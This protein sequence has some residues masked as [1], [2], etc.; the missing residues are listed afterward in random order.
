MASTNDP[1]QF[2]EF[3]EAGNLLEANRDATTISIEDDDMPERQRKAAGFTPDVDDEDPHASDDNTELLSGQKK[4]APFWTFEYY[5]RFFDIET[6]HVKERIIGSM[7]PWPGKNFI[8]VHL[9]RSP[10][11]Y[12]PFWICT[13]LVF[14]LAISGNIS[15]FLLYLGKPNHKYSPQF[16]KV[17]IAAT[18]I[19]SYAWFV[20][21]ALWGC[22]LWRNNKIMNSVS[23]SFIE[24]VCVYG[25]SL[26]IYIPAVVL[27]I[28]PFE[29]LR[30]C[31][32][33]MAL[34]LSGSVLVMTFWPAV[35]E[36][37][38]KVIAAIM[39]AIVLLNVL[40]AV[41]CQA[42][43][44]SKPEAALSPAPSAALELTKA[45]SAT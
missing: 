17:T 37:Y 36:D 33:V 43:F 41:G 5:Q 16:G 45:P 20:P 32:I 2:Q 30:W 13:T 7:L 23:Y 9:R 14:A 1:F 24:I 31:S 10:D 19:F 42:Y 28:L 4:S 6:H 39:S 8:H 25:Y 40:L 3:E 34:C 21:L 27:W 22:L 29:W 18:A 44:F 11:L 15:N 35:R 38:P 26:A 12:G